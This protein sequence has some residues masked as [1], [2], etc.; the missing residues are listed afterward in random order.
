MRGKWFA[1]ALETCSSSICVYALSTEVHDRERAKGN[2]LDMFYY[3]SKSPDRATPTVTSS[4]EF[5][6]SWP[7]GLGTWLPEQPF[8]LL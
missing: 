6:P 3:N 2:P 1:S 8:R 7:F 5:P 4:L